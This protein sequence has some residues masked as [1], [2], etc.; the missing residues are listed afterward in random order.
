MAVFDYFISVTGDCAN[1]NVGAISLSLSGGTPPYTVEW[2][3]PPIG[4]SITTD[5]FPIYQTS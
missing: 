5:V 3:E 1:T 4:A 2:I